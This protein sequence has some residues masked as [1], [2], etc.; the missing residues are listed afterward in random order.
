M[1]G[2]QAGRGPS[3]AGAWLIWVGRLRHPSASPSA[4]LGAAAKTG[5]ALEAAPF[6]VKV[7]FKIK[8]TI[9]TI[10]IKGKRTKPALSLPKGV[11]APHELV[12]RK[13]A[14][15][16]HMTTLKFRGRRE[17]AG[18]LTSRANASLLK[19]IPDDSRYG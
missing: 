1:T 5:R 10:K 17:L 16:H 19:T 13:R 14:G 3:A 8:I 9:T 18:L 6:P 7:K 15:F 11:S 4:S 2:L 12:K